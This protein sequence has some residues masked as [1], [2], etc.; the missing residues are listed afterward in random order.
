M[1]KDLGEVRGDRHLEIHSA[2]HSSA[3]DT[4][5]A[6][7]AAPSLSLPSPA[8]SHGV[9]PPH[10]YTRTSR[11]R[12][13]LSSRH[14]Q[15]T[16][17]RESMSLPKTRLVPSCSLPLPCPSQLPGRHQRPL[18]KVLLPWSYLL[19]NPVPGAAQRG[20]RRRHWWPPRAMS[21]WVWSI[22]RDRESTACRTACARASAPPW[23]PPSLPS[24]PRAGQKA[25]LKVK[26]GLRPPSP[27]G[28]RRTNCLVFQSKR[29]A[30]GFPREGITASPPESVP[31]AGKA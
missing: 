4:A 20:P 10:M 28:R 2:A 30:R 13:F 21:R 19:W 9:Q 12:G 24:P 31:A 22:S 3:P 8:R 15:A 27:L 7:T 23:P 11:E 26:P 18:P 25:H 1:A 17:R 16:T 29:W 6:R 14:P 5:R